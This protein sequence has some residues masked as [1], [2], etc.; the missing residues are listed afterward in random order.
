MNDFVEVKVQELTGTALDWAVA[1]A[2]GLKAAIYPDKPR[3]VF[4]DSPGSGCGPY[5]P[6]LSWAQGGP[7]LEKHGIN[8]EQSSWDWKGTCI[9]W[10]AKAQVDSAYFDHVNL[11]V[12]VM[13]AVV[14][15]NL[16]D[17][18]SVPSELME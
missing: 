7:L 1:Q 8:T 2:E 16:G 14:H 6:S 3:Y 12:A 10:R 4:I 11:L 5:H 9:L 13:R 18:V 15:A 17:T